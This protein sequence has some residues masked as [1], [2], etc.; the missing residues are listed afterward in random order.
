[1][2]LATPCFLILGGG[3]QGRLGLC[4]TMGHVNALI[5]VLAIKNCLAII[6]VPF[7][8]GMGLGCM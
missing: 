6:E 2:L 1:M 3:T 4:R 8:L 5:V 7:R